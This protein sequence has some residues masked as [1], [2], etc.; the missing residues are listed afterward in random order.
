[1]GKYHIPILYGT[2]VKVG[3]SALQSNNVTV[4]T[5]KPVNPSTLRM[6]QAS[7]FWAAVKVYLQC[8]VFKCLVFRALAV[9]EMGY[10]SVIDRCNSLGYIHTCQKIIDWRKL[11]YGECEHAE[12]AD[13]PEPG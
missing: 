1:M 4:Y 3:G 7:D 9:P 2:P 11:G 8:F 13:A 6:K 12:H 10:G 5:V